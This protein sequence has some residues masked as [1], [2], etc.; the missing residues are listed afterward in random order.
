MRSLAVLYKIFE[1]RTVIYFGTN[2]EEGTVHCHVLYGL[3][4]FR[5]VRTDFGTEIEGQSGC[6]VVFL[7]SFGTVFKESYNH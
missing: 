3:G 2:F 5:T 4:K 7:E 6:C 1:F